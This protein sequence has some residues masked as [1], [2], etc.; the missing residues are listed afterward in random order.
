M[1]IVQNTLVSDDVVRQAFICNLEKCK[2][3]C[4]VEGDLGAPLAEDELPVI[5]A[6]YP[7]VKPYLTPEGREQIESFGYYETD[8]DGEHTT[9]LISNGMCAY[10][11]RNES[12]LVQCGF[13]LAYRDG[14]TDFPKPVSCHLYP[15]RVNEI[16]GTIAVNYHEWDIC[17]A[18]CVLGKNLSVP[19]YQFLK[20]ALIRR[21]GQ[22]WYDELLK[23]ISKK[24]GDPQVA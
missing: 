8:S 15:V 19:L 24:T 1:L 16:A 6:I 14:L 7:A 18:A 22:Q 2:G 10:G 5:E 20:E 21:F 4:C 3:A 11:R 23:E 9:P 17:A 12:G 13:E